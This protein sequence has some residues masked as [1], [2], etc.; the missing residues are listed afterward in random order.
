MQNNLLKS[1][2]ST[3]TCLV[4]NLSVQCSQAGIEPQPF[5]K[6]YYCYTLLAVD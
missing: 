2:R 3:Y 5:A 6:L 4:F 1:T